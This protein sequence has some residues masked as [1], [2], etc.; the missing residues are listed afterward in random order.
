MGE[1]IGD[2]KNRKPNALDADATSS[3]TLEDLEQSEKNV[4][5][6]GSENEPGPSPDGQL[7]EANEIKDAGPM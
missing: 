3:E 2:S 1:T 7:D 6:D 5:S 4:G